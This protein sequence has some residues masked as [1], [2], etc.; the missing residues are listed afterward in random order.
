LGKLKWLR[1]IP[2]AANF[3]LCEVLKGKARQVHRDL[4][5]KGILVRYFDQPLL[6]NYIRISVG[7]PADTDA[8]IRTLREIGG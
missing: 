1:P 7:T 6:E 4:R 5:N 8:L 3:V 2:S